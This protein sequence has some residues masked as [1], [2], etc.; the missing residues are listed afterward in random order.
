MIV[1]PRVRNCVDPKSDLFING[2][3]KSVSNSIFTSRNDEIIRELNTHFASLYM[4]FLY[5]R[6]IIIRRGNQS[7]RFM[8]QLAQPK[9][10]K[11]DDRPCLIWQKIFID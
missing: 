6:Y 10:I 2:N 4:E 8:K 9:R 5:Y 11:I 7:V 1:G 3:L